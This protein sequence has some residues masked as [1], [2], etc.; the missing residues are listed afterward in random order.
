M[1]FSNEPRQIKYNEH[2]HSY[3][4]TGDLTVYSML[5]QHNIN[6]VIFMCHRATALRGHVQMFTIKRPTDVTAR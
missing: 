4:L 1:Q 3:P 5:L 2:E 6:K